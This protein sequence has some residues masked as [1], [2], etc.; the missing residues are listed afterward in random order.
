MMNEEYINEHFEKI[1]VGTHRWKFEPRVM[2]GQS[3]AG[4]LYRYFLTFM[5]EERRFILSRQKVQPVDSVN[6]DE[7][8]A[9]FRGLL[10]DVE[11]AACMRTAIATPPPDDPIPF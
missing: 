1:E 8:L 11:V 5:R 3:M 2:W 10:T 6:D 4:H 7:Q 9:V